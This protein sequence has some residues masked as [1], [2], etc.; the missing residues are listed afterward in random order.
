M[1]FTFKIL[2]F[3]SILLFLSFITAPQDL[4]LWRNNNSL[5]IKDFQAIQKDTIQ[6]G[7]KKFLGAISAIYIEVITTQ[8]SRYT[9]PKLVVKN[10]FDKQQSWML[11]KNDYVLQHEQI[12]F[13]ISELYARKIRKSADSLARK[14]ITNLSVYRNMV[15]DWEQKKQKTNDQFD[16][17][18][19]DSFLK[20]GKEIFFKKNPKQKEWL[21]KINLE[22]QKLNIYTYENSL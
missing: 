20:I 16:A 9:P 14:N 5:Q 12:H 18:N 2:I 8:K 3:S 19:D 6:T 1:K 11:V 15:N 10:Y 13:N 21:D 22:L 4:I 17:E 7:N